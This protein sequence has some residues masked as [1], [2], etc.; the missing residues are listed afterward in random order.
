M[1]SLSAAAL[2][3]LQTRHGTEPV[4][5]LEIQW[6]Q[7]GGWSQYADRNIS[8][9][10]D[11][12]ILELSGLDDVINISGSEDSQEIS[13]ILDDTDGTMKNIFNNYDIHGRD[14]RVW[15]WFDGLSLDD[16]FL[17]FKGKINSPIE[18]KEGD[19]TLSFSVLSQIE[20]KE[21]G[22]TPEEGDFTFIPD[23]L[24]G[25]PWPSCFGY[26]KNVPALRIGESVQG[27]TLAGT[28]CITGAGQKG[29][30][31]YGV[32]VE[33]FA[34]GSAVSNIQKGHL[35]FVGSAWSAVNGEIAEKFQAQAAQISA[36]LAASAS[37]IITGVSSTVSDAKDQIDEI[38]A[39]DVGSFTL[40][41][42]GGELFPRGTIRI[43]VGGITLRGAFGGENNDNLFTIYSRSHTDDQADYNA[44]ILASN[45][46]A[47][48]GGSAGGARFDH[49]HQ[50]PCR[51]GDCVYRTY[52]SIYSVSV[53]VGVQ[54]AVMPKYKWEQAG[55]AVTLIGNE[56]IS[57]IVSIVPGTVRSVKAYQTHHGIK[58]LTDVPSNLYTVTNNTYGDISAVVVTLNKT[59][60]TRDGENW[61][62]DLF[63]S[64]ESSIGSDV[65]D[66]L[67]YI[68]GLYTDFS[69]D[70]TSFNLA[71]MKASNQPVD[72]AV[73]DRKNVLTILQEISWQA[74]LTLRLINDT[75]YLNHWPSTQSAVDTISE[76]DIST[77]TL[78]VTSTD[79]EDLVTKLVAEWRPSYDKDLNKLILR[80]NVKKYG[81]HEE[82]FDFYIYNSAALVQKNATFW[83][84]RK[85][86]IWKHIQFETF[87]S[88]LNLESFDHV[89][90]NFHTNYVS[91]VTCKAVITGAQVNTD[92][93]TITFTA[94]TPVKLGEMTPYLFAWPA[95][96]SLQEIFPTQDEID[97]GYAGG[98][99]IGAGSGGTLPPAPQK[100]GTSYE[101]AT[102]TT[103]PAQDLLPQRR[104][105]L[106]AGLSDW[107]AKNPSKDNRSS[108]EAQRII[109]AA[110]YQASKNNTGTVNTFKP[111]PPVKIGASWVYPTGPE[112]P[113][114]SV[115]TG[116][117]F[118]IDISNTLVMDGNT[119][120]ETSELS[121]ILRFV[122]GEVAISTSAK[123]TDG[124]TTEEFDFRYDDEGS[125][126]GAGTAFL[127]E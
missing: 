107:G 53:G 77:N 85:A 3:K 17:L 110:S 70:S 40:R 100:G 61:G 16:K 33:N 119:G 95:S 58:Y 30:G 92:Q 124:E 1:R 116:D 42:L 80:H 82:V 91:N 122:D 127:K 84:I 123:F 15:Q 39:G 120:N 86:N 26:P 121:D 125:K 31:H 93:Y 90:L 35:S 49:S 5:I 14:V 20:D 8:T 81:T 41:I 104:R 36:S 112:P 97:K 25:T 2:T 28:G 54:D 79:T 66:V 75:F 23:D 96:V 11:G 48:A 43:Q 76:E 22:F 73:L 50:V 74:C 21:F 59:L 37:Q 47:P 109:R 63:V 111:L 94:W 60:S 19:Q 7:A 118:V 106:N 44:E 114:A 83:I 87:M 101:G 12:K 32:A 78:A 67:E 72:F 113:Q 18:W 55:A 103:R 69:I 117:A 34:S 46:S 88:K 71:S 108:D 56:P 9:V 65:V 105:G 89:N 10:V 52:G 98:D 6:V 126:Y 29:D 68:I 99:G 57:Y 24:I 115:V 38:L 62:D 4:V 13:V 64:F 45:K 27:T 51:G 102:G